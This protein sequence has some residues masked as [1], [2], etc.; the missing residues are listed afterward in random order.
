MKKI[1]LAF[2]IHNHQPVGNFD[3]VF[4]DAYHRAYLPFLEL[5]EKHPQ[6]RIAQHY[7][8]I[9]L[10]WI[11]QHKPDFIPRLQKLVQSG[12]VEMMTG[13]YYEPI[14]AVIPYEDKIGQIQKLTRFLEQHTGYS[15]QGMWLAERIW[16]PHLPKPCVEA[17]VKYVILDDSHF[18]NAGLKEEQLSGYYV[19]EEEGASL[20]LFPI[21]EKL[22]YTIPFQPVEE[23][24]NYLQEVASNT[25][26]TLVVFADDGEK[27][28]IWPNTYEHC[29]QKGWLEEFFQA[30]EENSQWIEMIHFSEALEKIKPLGRIYLPTASYREMMEWAM[31]TKAIHEY[32]KFESIL[33]EHNLFDRYKVFVRGGFW[34]NFMA[35]YP[36]SNNMHKKMLYL[37]RRLKS[38][39]QKFG[40]SEMYQQARDH[41]WA[42]QCNCP[43]W[44]GVFGGLYLNHLRYATYNH[45]IQ[46]EILIDQMEHKNADFLESTCLDFD[47]DGFQEVLLR[48]QTL[49]LY[50]SPEQGGSLF[51]LDFK[52]RAINLL[53]TLTR[54][55]ES[56]HKKI[57]QLQS[58]K[59]T[60][61]EGKIASIHDLVVAKETG[62]ERYL[63]Y[64][65]YRRTSLLDHF[66]APDTTLK[67]FYQSNY[68][69][70]GKFINYPY[71]F[72]I[73]KKPDNLSLKLWRRGKIWHKNQFLPVYLEKRISINALDSI[74]NINYILKNLSEI[75]VDL[76]FGVEFDFALLAGDAPDRYYQ[77]PGHKLN[78]ANLRSMGEI[79][80]ATTAILVDEWLKIRITLELEQQANFWR[81]PIETISQS[82][83]GFER[84][85]QSSVIFPHWRFQLP[86][87]NV[88]KTNLV[89]KIEAL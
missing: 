72:A 22:R 59:S 38:L 40:D 75:P 1:Y 3:F 16:E 25:P 15:P 45:F 84:V 10:E 48:N 19:T 85:Y 64:D 13:G 80:G 53:D 46:A 24:L 26:D 83:M 74:L 36:E 79:K 77:F 21:S 61:T 54:R 9:L 67:A 65:W 34:R 51:E 28:G 63:H 86:A 81:F 62:L 44:H 7:S 31:P 87:G 14:L 29:Y 58:Q 55:E 4:N 52:P 30:L 50:F 49:N 60:A 32:E 37:S 70:A 68:Q 66:L 11:Q 69:E 56:Y 76:L 33:K 78:E 57:L 42:G 18:K 8:G 12:Q 82:E 17:G 73:E 27:F 23:T 43:Y 6:I 5:L 47:N 20:Y 39:Q 41:I 89:L 71:E 35:K 88:W 2:G